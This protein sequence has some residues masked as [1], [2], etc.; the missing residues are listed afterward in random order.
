MD[1]LTFISD[2]TMYLL[3][4]VLPDA[5]PKQI[6]LLLLSIVGLVIVLVMFAIMWSLFNE[7]PALQKDLALKDETPP[8]AK[9]TAKAKPAKAAKS[10]SKTEKAAPKKAGAKKAGTQKAVAKKAV[11]KNAAVDVPSDD[12]IEADI[13][14]PE[15]TAGGFSFFKRESSGAKVDAELISIEQEMLAI[16]QLY[17][18]ERITKDVYVVETRRLYE[19]ASALRSG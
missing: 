7:K 13:S 19:K 17:M 14:A 11:A 16:R 5:N 15:A 9:K 3:S 18:D 4:V 10:A 2:Q 1:V 12:D 8:K 6:R